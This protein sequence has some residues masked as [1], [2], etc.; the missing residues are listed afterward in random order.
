[1]MIL[2]HYFCIGNWGLNTEGQNLRGIKKGW[3]I[4]FQQKG[5]FTHNV[6]SVLGI[7]VIQ[8]HFRK[9][10]PLSLGNT[11]KISRFQKNLSTFY[12]NTLPYCTVKLYRK[13]SIDDTI[14]G[15]Q[16]I[17]RTSSG[18]CSPPFY[19]ENHYY[20]DISTSREPTIRVSGQL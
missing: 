3:N 15:S 8:K 17:H 13:T 19:T 2:Y 10:Q 20:D 4:F 12:F 18:I 9:H 7:G 14:V 1:M 5:H 11:Q 16:G 6:E